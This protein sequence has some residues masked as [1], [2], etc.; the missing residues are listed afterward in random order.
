MIA[1]MSALFSS[2]TSEDRHILEEVNLYQHFFDNIKNHKNIAYLLGKP[3]S[4]CNH[5]GFHFLES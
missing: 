4:L 1:K 5:K 2:E 3:M